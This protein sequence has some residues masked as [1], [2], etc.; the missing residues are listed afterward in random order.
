ML[1]DQ[2]A[3]TLF[4]YPTPVILHDLDG[5]GYL[6]PDLTERILAKREAD[7][8]IKRSNYGGWHSEVDMMVWAEDAARVI[9]GEAINVVA[10]A[11]ADIHPHGKRDFEFDVQMWA[12]VS[13]PGNS[14]QMHCHPGALWS[15]VYYVDV[16][17]DS[18]DVDVEG[19]LLLVDPRFPTNVMYMP[20]LVNRYPDGKPQYSQTP[21]RPKNGRMVL[22]PAWM[23]HSVRPYKGTRERIS[24]AFN[25]MVSVADA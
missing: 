11:T 25:L 7:A 10:S 23:N 2:P 12:N 8:G 3:Q 6:N 24:I 21:I 5:A 4:L 9:L 18:P 19:E 13:G 16:G 17:E 15:G 22:F 14:N 20:E 1:T